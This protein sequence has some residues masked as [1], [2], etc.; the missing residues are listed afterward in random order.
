MTTTALKKWEVQRRLEEIDRQLYWAGSVGRTDLIA[1]FGI[2]PQQASADLK[3]YLDRLGTAVRF[4]GS[5]KRYVPTEKFQPEFIKPCIED[6]ISWAGEIGHAA[7]IVPLPFRSANMSVLQPVT[8]A[9]HQ[10]R[11]IEIRYRSLTT[12]EGTVRRITPHSI[13]F[14][15]TRYHVRA[16]CHRS[17]EFR[18]FVLGRVIETYTFDDAGPGK[19]KDDAWNTL[20]IVRIGPHPELT[21]AQR[22]VIEADYAMTDGEAKIHIKQALLLYL[23]DQFNLFERESDRAAT[24]QQI[25]LLNPEICQLARS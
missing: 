25:V 19:D 1:R 7:T 21:V 17:E 18:D 20:I 24:V 22:T 14:T 16:F 12:P 9:I 4:N 13:V 8:M 3:L 5:I 23:L 10:R 11:S 15:G 6:Y 2:S